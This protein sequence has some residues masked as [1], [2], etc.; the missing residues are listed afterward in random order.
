MQPFQPNSLL[1][2]RFLL[3]EQLSFDTASQQQVW[4]VTDTQT[5][6][7]LIGRFHSNGQI[8]WYNDNRN[9]A[10]ANTPAL[11]FPAISQSGETVGHH[12]GP[13]TVSG[14]T[15]GNTLP[16]PGNTFAT[17]PKRAKGGILWFLLVVLAGLAIAAYFNQEFVYGQYNA[18]RAQLF[19]QPDSLQAGPV[20]DQK[21]VK[22]EQETGLF[23]PS[24]E[25]PVWK[26]ESE[27]S[28][29]GS[30][31]N[32]ASEVPVA[33]GQSD[34][35][36]RALFRIVSRV[37]PFSE[38]NSLSHSFDKTAAA[39]IEFRKTGGRQG[40][41]DSVYTIATDRADQFYQSFKNGR[42]E[43]KDKAIAWYKISRAAKE[44]EHNKKR[45]SELLTPQA[46]RETSSTRPADYFP[47]DPELNN[48]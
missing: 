25:V 3:K 48:N 5:G 11:P 10:P 12:P 29:V 6:Q 14:T 28:T 39:L 20:T 15:S 27:T 31:A 26:P 34:E 46:K 33:S 16:P 9:V 36:I 4:T 37:D 7:A 23:G 17:P 35:Q 32:R 21:Q 41:S 42:V 40:L 22:P 13:Q 45:L 18:I 38:I 1:S 44:T 8:D 43:A 19:G 2:G 30:V 24:S 47:R